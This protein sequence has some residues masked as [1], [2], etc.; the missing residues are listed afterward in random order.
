MRERDVSDWRLTT[1]AECEFMNA[2][3]P[4]LYHL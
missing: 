4:K 1:S 3:S 2:E